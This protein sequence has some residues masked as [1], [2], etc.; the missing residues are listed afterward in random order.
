METRPLPS[1]QSSLSGAFTR[2]L[3]AATRRA[4]Q[5]LPPAE[6]HSSLRRSPGVPRAKPVTR[7]ASELEAP[8]A[9]TH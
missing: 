1:L 3:F 2:R 4:S 7:R 8:R 6:S 9:Q 5:R